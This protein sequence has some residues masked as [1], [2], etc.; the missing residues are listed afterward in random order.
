LG[1]CNLFLITAGIIES[2]K[3]IGKKFAIVVLLMIFP[4]RWGKRFQCIL[5]GDAISTAF[6]SSGMRMFIK[7]IGEKG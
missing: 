2:V 3:L 6:S 4:R 5:V 7:E 1:F